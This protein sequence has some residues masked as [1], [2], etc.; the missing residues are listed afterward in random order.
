MTSTRTTGTSRLARVLAILPGRE[1][2][3]R[4][5]HVLEQLPGAAFLV[6]RRTRTILAVNGKA[7]T[8]TE[9]TRNELG[10]RT[11]ADM[12]APSPA[13]I[14]TLA[15]FDILEPGNQRTLL[16]IPLRTRSSRVVTVD[17][18]LSAFQENGEVVLL[19]LATPV[20]ER[21][22]QE[23]EVTRNS[24]AMETLEQL[25]ALSEAPTEATL[26][27]AVRLA[28]ALMDADA[29][30]LYWVTTDSPGPSLRKKHVDGVPASFPDIIGPGEAQHFQMPLRWTS[31]QHTD[32]FLYQVLRAAGWAHFMAYPIG[33]PANLVASVFIAYRASHH[34]PPLAT[35]LLSVVAQQFDHLITQINRAAR[36][37]KTQDLAIRL[38]SHLAAINAQI[39]E[40]TILLNPDGD[41][42]EINNAAAQMLGYRSEDVVGL[43]FENVLISD[44]PLNETLRAGL[45][46]EVTEGVEDK[47]LRRSGE[48]FPVLLRARPLPESGC[49]LTLRDLSE[50]RANE[51]RREHLDHL[52]YVGQSTESFA[53]EVRAP[54]NNIS[55]GVQ[56]LATRLAPDDLVQLAIARIQA[57]CNRLSEL[58][59]D[60]LAWAKPVDPKF[61][62]TDVA[63]LL[64]RLASRWSYK[65]Q[66]RNVRLNL[67]LDDCPRVFADV[68]LIERVIVN[69]IE[70]AL[71]A[72]PAGGELFI[73]LRAIDRGPQGF[74]VEARVGDSG[75]GIADE[76]RRHVFDPYFTTKPDGTGLGLAI[77]KRLVT[78]HRGAIDV[79][80]FPGGGTV[81][82]VTLPAYD[83][84]RNPSESAI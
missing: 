59:K 48:P 84:S 29:A 20:E 39:D 6:F 26:E 41:I 78:I 15:R 17:L 30:G 8:L 40:G 33:A 2:D 83:P 66:Q 3:P 82:V 54:L 71:Q 4:F 76:V 61:E 16:T 53:H 10:E 13:V 73:G 24:R 77:C 42:E 9:W 70:N 57:E 25:L 22:L 47:M 37:S 69:L 7:I 56:F 81:F 51:V 1:S 79:E 35:A 31:G 60:M 74:L 34:P 14:E 55:M 58:M 75:P 43:P 23:Q 64:S 49:V 62:P 27:E 5:L 38:S 19:V 21:I 63:L 50:R 12:L 44:G 36:L 18:R 45:Q 68:P 72:M 80:S 67:A 65:I 52:A 32:P 28:R 11:F 46:G